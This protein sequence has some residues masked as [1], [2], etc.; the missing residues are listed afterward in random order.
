MGEHCFSVAASWAGE[1]GLQLWRVGAVIGIL[2]YL[3]LTSDPKGKMACLWFAFWRREQKKA[4]VSWRTSPRAVVVRTDQ[5]SEHK[6]QSQTGR[7]PCLFMTRRLLKRCFSCR[8]LSP[9]RVPPL[10]FPEINTSFPR[11][12]KASP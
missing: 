8:A 6:R 3:D 11:Q 10:L 5:G 1:T 9:S 4:E 7:G 2:L 12:R